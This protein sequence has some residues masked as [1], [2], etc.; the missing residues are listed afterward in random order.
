MPV[1]PLH[2]SRLLLRVMR[3]TD[4]AV[5]AAY[6]NDPA[7]ALHQ[8]WDLPFALTDAVALL[9][10]QDDVDDLVP[11]RWLQIGLETADGTVVG[12]AA[13]GIDSTG[14]IA[15]LGYSLAVEHQGRGYATE[16][17]TALIDAVFAG[18]T[19]HRILA[20]VDPANHASL[21]VVEPLGFRYEG[22]ARRAAPVRGAWADDLRFA[23][24]REDRTAWLN[25][26]TSP[27][28]EV[29]LVPLTAD[30]LA[31]VRRLETFRFQRAFVA[32][33]DA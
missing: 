17:A 32:P 33:V 29:D 14:A 28:T 9:E 7:V 1:L 12:D 5:L 21:R 13:V 6:R 23:L 8:D 16:A 15:V 31:E 27:P 30:R 24:L 20:T 2:T 25:R 26:T 3:S 4:A 11:G 22:L 18:T 10:K 19:V